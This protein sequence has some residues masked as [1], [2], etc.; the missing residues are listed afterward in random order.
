M[1]AQPQANAIAGARNAEQAAQN[2]QA[3]EVK[4]SNDEL[5][6][7]DAIGRIVTNHLDDGAVMWEWN[8]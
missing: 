8:S 7:I 4:L 3:A 1:I 5:K 2:A 6:E